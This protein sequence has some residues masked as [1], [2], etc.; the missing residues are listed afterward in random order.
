MN[1]KGTTQIVQPKPTGSDKVTKVE[2]QSTE[3]SICGQTKATVDGRC[4]PCW[5]I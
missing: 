2:K 1:S 3:C 4:L 5:C